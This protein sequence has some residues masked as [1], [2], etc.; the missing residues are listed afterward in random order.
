MDRRERA[1]SRPLVRLRPRPPRP[2]RSRRDRRS[3]GAR[4]ARRAG[5]ARPAPV[6]R[7]ALQLGKLR[8]SF[9]RRRE[10]SFEE[11]GS[12]LSR[13]RLL[14]A[15]IREAPFVVPAEAGTPFSRTNG[16]PAFAG[17]TCLG[18]LVATLDLAL[19]VLAGRDHR[20]ARLLAGAETRRHALDLLVVV[21]MHEHADR[22]A[23][24][25]RAAEQRIRHAMQRRSPAL[26]G[27]ARHH[28]A[29]VD[30]E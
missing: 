1:A 23:T 10:P 24:A 19:D 28:V 20:V 29:E 16:I 9:P 3:G 7:G 12:P 18:S 30:D 8:S 25:L 15:S 17:T 27:P 2:Y 5:A 21:R 14:R 4:H 22:K 11:T 6:L 26:V 13:G